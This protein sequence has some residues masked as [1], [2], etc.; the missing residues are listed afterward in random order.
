MEQ[1]FESAEQ[2]LKAKLSLLATGEAISLSPAEAAIYEVAH[3][4]KLPAG[5]E[6]DD[7]R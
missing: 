1:H 4:D 5:E 7:D 6:D 3:A 2:S